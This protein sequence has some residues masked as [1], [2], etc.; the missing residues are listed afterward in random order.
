MAGRDLSAELFDTPAKPE[1]APPSGKDLSA[2]LF[3]S[4]AKPAPKAEAKPAAC[5]T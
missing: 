2:E 1:P 4:P 5:Q 3:G